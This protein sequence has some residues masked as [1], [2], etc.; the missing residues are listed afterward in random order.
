MTT[1]TSLETAFLDLINQTRAS[2][3]AK[4]L[5]FDGELLDAADAHSA[6]ID[7][8]D[9]FSHSGVN[10]SSVGDRLTA[11]GYGA[12]GWGENIAYVSGGMTEATVEQLHTNLVN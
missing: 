8:T 4:P 2:V 6:W 11:A 7:Q 9:T 10:G 1:P 5:S 3:G 12:Q